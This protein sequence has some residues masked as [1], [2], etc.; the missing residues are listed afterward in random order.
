MNC[1]T[2]ILVYCMNYKV[3]I[4]R[5]P[6][7]IT[8]CCVYLVYYKNCTG[9]LCILKNIVYYKNCTG[10]L[11]VVYILYIIR[12]V[13]KFLRLSL[14]VYIYSTHTKESSDDDV[15]VVWWWIVWIV[16]K[17]LYIK[18]PHCILYWNPLRCMMVDCTGIPAMY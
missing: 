2:G 12:I 9:I 11:C 8:L 13:L 15:A 17:T 14:C 1:C 6:H 5:I 18:N 3:V 4:I 7:W 10:I 16:L